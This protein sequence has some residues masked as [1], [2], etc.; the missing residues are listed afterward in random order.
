MF[1]LST[2]LYFLV[3]SFCL[4]LST[5]SLRS[6]PV[7]AGKSLRSFHPVENPKDVVPLRR[8]NWIR[9]VVPNKLV[10]QCTFFLR[11]M[12]HAGPICH[13]LQHFGGEAPALPVE[14]CGKCLWYH[15]LSSLSWQQLRGL[16][17]SYQRGHFTG[18]PKCLLNRE[19]H[20]TE[21]LYC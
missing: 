8:S 9:G 4:E 3:S 6:A 18:F 1:F 5:C 7:R 20:S 16:R 2:L 11:N 14:V 12:D 15:C 10:V 13:T 21:I 19:P 17:K